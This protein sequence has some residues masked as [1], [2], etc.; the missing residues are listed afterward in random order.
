AVGA[1]T[2]TLVCSNTGA[3]PAKTRVAP[4]THC[5]VTHGPLPA[6]GTNGQPA[7]T[8]GLNIVAI[9]M[10]LNSTRG[11]GTA[12]CACPAW[13]HRTV[14]PACTRNPGIS[15]HHQRR[16]VDHHAWSNHVDRRSLSVVNE[17]ARV[18]DN[19]HCS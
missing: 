8:Y 13:E 14:A 17:D 9:G 19:D 11:N 7:I 4:T 16:F 15:D 5:A 2:A 10:S 1:Q 3:P 6:G 18:V 12:G